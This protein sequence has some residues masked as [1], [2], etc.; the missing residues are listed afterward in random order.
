[1]LRIHSPSLGCTLFALSTGCTQ[2]Y[3]PI[4]KTISLICFLCTGCAKNNQLKVYKDASVFFFFQDLNF[5]QQMRVI[6]LQLPTRSSLKGQKYSSLDTRFCNFCS[7]FLKNNKNNS[8]YFINIFMF[9][10]WEF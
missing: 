9:G 5:K 3:L 7:H 4:L 2:N 8:I 6:L 10:F 1:M